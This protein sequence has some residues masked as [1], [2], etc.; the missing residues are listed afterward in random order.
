MLV[1]GVRYNL[2][3]PGAAVDVMGARAEQLARRVQEFSHKYAHLLQTGAATP[4][5]N[6]GNWLSPNRSAQAGR[7]TQTQPAYAAPEVPVDLTKESNGL[8]TL[9]ENEFLTR[10]TQ[11]GSNVKRIQ[12]F[13]V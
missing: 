5:N 11:L 4:F 10:F 3:L 13:V 12:Q 2:R 7:R 6:A 8:A 9:T 1:C